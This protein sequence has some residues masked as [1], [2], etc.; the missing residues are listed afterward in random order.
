[1]SGRLIERKNGNR[2]GTMPA[3]TFISNH[4]TAFGQLTTCVNNIGYA[5]QTSH[6]RRITV[7]PSLPEGNNPS[8]VL[9]PSGAIRL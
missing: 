3:L 5:S 7:L 4:T 2:D 8:R 9:S 6:L 1:I